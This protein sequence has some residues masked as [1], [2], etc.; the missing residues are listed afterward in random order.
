MVPMSLVES[1]SDVS[2]GQPP[3]ALA[4][5]AQ[6]SFVVIAAYNEGGAIFDVVQELRAVYP[7]VVVVDDGSSDDTAERAQAAGA[8]VLTHL[9]NRGQGA[10]LQTGISYAL[11][12]GAEFVAT[13]D[14]DGQHDVAD[15]AGMLGPIERGEVEICLGSR[16]LER[17]E[18]IPFVRRLVL[19]AAVLFMRV[20]ARA[21]LT[22]AHN[23][24]RAFSR[25]AALAL[26]LR[27]DRM[28]HASEIVDQIV[29]S[30][31]PFTE[32][33]VRIRYTEYSLRKG[34]RSSA[35]LR[36]AFDYLMG[37]LIR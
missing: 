21:R 10:A 25:R 16:F 15:L 11:M 33:P 4:R 1:A 13:F 5:L 2:T 30:G 14:A 32:V 7:N 12:Q 36:V 19:Y 23:G 34:Q 17:R 24:L 8:C 27:L 26:D 6:R 20:T 18:K 31:L 37:R 29:S 28:A 22:D 9:I 35:A 3:V